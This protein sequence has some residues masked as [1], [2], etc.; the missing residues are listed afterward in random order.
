MDYLQEC[1]ECLLFGTGIGDEEVSRLIRRVNEHC[2]KAGANPL[3][4]TRRCCPLD[5]HQPRSCHPGK[6]CF[7]VIKK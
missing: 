7:I 5:A 3:Q 1:Y 4:P 6:I 2:P